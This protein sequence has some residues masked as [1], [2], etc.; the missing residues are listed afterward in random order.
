MAVRVFEVFVFVGCWVS[1]RDFRED[2]NGDICLEDGILERGTDMI[3]AGIATCRRMSQKFQQKVLFPESLERKKLRSSRD[4]NIFRDNTHGCMQQATFISLLWNLLWNRGT[5]HTLLSQRKK[6]WYGRSGSKLS[7]CMILIP[8]TELRHRFAQKKPT[9]RRSITEYTEK[10][11]IVNLPVSHQWGS[12]RKQRAPH[13][14][15]NCKLDPVAYYKHQT[16]LVITFRCAVFCLLVAFLLLF[17][18]HNHNHNHNRSLIP[19][20]LSLQQ[21]Q[22]YPTSQHPQKKTNPLLLIN[23]NTTTATTPN[24][25]KPP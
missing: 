7:S 1:V 4:W 5:Q 19:T 3:F 18:R 2:N 11:S 10:C 25:K 17:T 13:Q 14:P 24:N 12:T 16:Q 22:R 6:K 9:N 15:T 20:R 8:N 23:D 21:T